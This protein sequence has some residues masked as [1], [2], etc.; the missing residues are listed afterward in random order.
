MKTNI[1]LFRKDIDDEFNKI[2]ENVKIHLEEKNDI[3]IKK[4]FL[5]NWIPKEVIASSKILLDT[6]V[7]AL[8]DEARTQLK[9]AS[10][11]LQ[12]KFYEYNFRQRIMEW[13]GQVENKLYLDPKNVRYSSDPRL[14]NGIVTAGVVFIAGTAIT[15]IAFIPMKGIKSIVGGM[16]TIILSAVAFKIAYNKAEHKALSK[17]KQ[18]IEYYLI[19][20]KN[21]VTEWL[22]KVIL[23]FQK[24]FESFCSSNGLE[25][26]DE[27]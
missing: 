2:R 24:E 17:M 20:T 13:A 7:N 6:V 9:G 14:I 12:N 19:N 16:V 8:M 26:S 27:K 3:E 11:E 25:V 15:G 21:Q 10:I 22:S 18:D 23:S 4:K 5:S 1:V